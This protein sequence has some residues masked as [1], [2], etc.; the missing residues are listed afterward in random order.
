[1]SCMPISIKALLSV[2][3]TLK[4][5]Y[6]WGEQTDET[7]L[8]LFTK[9]CGECHFYCSE[10]VANHE[11]VLFCMQAFV[12]N[13]IEYYKGKQAEENAEPIVWGE[14]YHILRNDKKTKRLSIM[15]LYVTLCMWNY[16]TEPKGWLE[17]KDYMK[18]ARREEYEKFKE[19]LEGMVNYLARFMVSR[20]PEYEKAEWCLE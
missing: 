9:L 5:S 19:K 8:G 11:A 10:A 16:N 12:F 14:I 15:Q 20:L 6:F 18:W 17:H 2:C 3:S 4:S 7:P 13:S 1:M